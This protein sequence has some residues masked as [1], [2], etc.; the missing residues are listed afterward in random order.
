MGVDDGRHYQSFT[1][2]IWERI[3]PLNGGLKPLPLMDADLIVVRASR[4]V[5][6][7]TADIR[8]D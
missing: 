3:L 4:R 8:R 6:F 1:Y 7:G 5:W 2:G